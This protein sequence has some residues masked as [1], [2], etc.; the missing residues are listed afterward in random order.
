VSRTTPAS[1]FSGTLRPFTNTWSQAN[2]RSVLPTPR[3][4]QRKPARSKSSAIQRLLKSPATTAGSGWRAASSTIA[5][6]W[7][8]RCFRL[9]PKGVSR[10]TL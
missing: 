6:A 4:V 10:C 5:R 8:S 3:V 9:M 7:S 2:R 1:G